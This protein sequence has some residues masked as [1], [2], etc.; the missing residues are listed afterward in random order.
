MTLLFV[1]VGNGLF[2]SLCGLKTDTKCVHFCN[3]SVPRNRNA[4]GLNLNSKS[5][6]R[7]KVTNGTGI[8][9]ARNAVPPNGGL[10]NSIR[11]LGRVGLYSIIAL[12]MLPLSSVV[13][14][15]NA[16]SITEPQRNAI[17]IQT[18]S[19]SEF[20]LYSVV[21]QTLQKESL[22]RNQLKDKAESLKRALNKRALQQ[23]VLL[24]KTKS[25]NN[26]SKYSTTPAFISVPELQYRLESLLISHPGIKTGLLMAALLLLVFG[27]G[28]LY[29]KVTGFSSGV[30]LWRTWCAVSGAEPDFSEDP[31]QGKALVIFMTI[32]QT[33]FFAFVLSLVETGIAGKL[34]ELK[35]GRTPVFES[36]HEVIL[37]W[38]PSLPRVLRQM[39][40]STDSNN[41]RRTVAILAPME[42]EDMDRT[43]SEAFE[44]SGRGL[45]VICRSGDPSDPDDQ[46]LVSA[47]KASRVLVLSSKRGQGSIY[48]SHVPS[49]LADNLVFKTALALKSRSA[50]DVRTILETFDSGSTDLLPYLGRQVTRLN[51][52]SLVNKQIVQ[53]ALEGKGLAEVQS[54]L[55]RFEG[56][57][58]YLEHYSPKNGETFGDVADRL[59]GGIALGVVRD[60]V[61]QRTVSDVDVIMNPKHNFPLQANDKIVYLAADKLK[62]RYLDVPEKTEN[63]QSSSSVAAVG[64]PSSEITSANSIRQRKKQ[65]KPSHLLVLGWRSGMRDMISEIDRYY[66]KGSKLTLVASNDINT[67]Q[68]ELA[69]GNGEK[70]SLQNIQLRHVVGDMAD[71]ELIRKWQKDVTSSSAARSQN[72]VIVLLDESCGAKTVNQ[73][74]SRVLQSLVALKA[75]IFDQD[76]S[77][78]SSKL[79]T[80]VAEVETNTTEELARVEAPFASVLTLDDF[81]SCLIAQAAYH[82]DILPV[83]ESLLSSSGTDI[84]MRPA[85]ALYRNN[86]TGELVVT[87]KSDAYTR[88]SSASFAELRLQCR[89]QGET[90]M[91]Y[92]TKDSRP[93]IVFGC[94]DNLDTQ[95]DLSSIEKLVVLTD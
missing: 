82:P 7:S 64:N 57:E 41:E 28:S 47:A 71:A 27:G 65:A 18:N 80:V 40:L 14:P 76:V 81:S 24:M 56:T 74:E 33:F 68:A 87:S 2:T 73:R 62:I 39:K 91:G 32:M 75:S 54:E 51:W 10:L 94:D 42:K 6:I 86:D 3:T 25:S 72:A 69:G 9:M 30:A 66:A 26:T 23:R 34:D 16:R 61:H 49:Q 43:V 22:I 59:R 38:N 85:D 4:P 67:R 93:E 1:G 88:A 45:H 63:A 20:N 55:I 60:H 19:N 77:N 70:L 52:S 11:N 92:T 84:R 36:R 90:L 31:W 46:K 83:W 21:H 58:L 95:I 50:G 37:G 13:P 17:S 89:N 79:P 44:S 29:Q 5:T 15:A 78:G 35:A 8:V 53:C 48:D 12:M